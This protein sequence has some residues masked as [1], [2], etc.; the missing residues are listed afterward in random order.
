M[1]GKHTGETEA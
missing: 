1:K